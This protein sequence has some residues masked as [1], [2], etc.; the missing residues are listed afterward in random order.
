MTRLTAS[1]FVTLALLL[2]CA[3]GGQI[4]QNETVATG[5]ISP[6]SGVTDL[7]GS[8]ELVDDAGPLE[9][10]TKPEAIWET[11]FE[12]LD[13]M[14]CAAGEGCFLDPCH[15][16]SECQS[17]WC[18]EHMGAG[19]CTDFCQEECPFG[20]SCKQVAGTGPDLIFVCVSDVANLC[21][22]CASGSDCKSVG[23]VDDV[24]VS[25]GAEGAFCGGT[26][27]DDEDCPQGFACQ[28]VQTVD[29]IQTTQCVSLS[30]QCECTE[31][32]IALSLWTPCSVDNEVG[33]C[34]GARICTAEGLTACD[35][36]VPAPE[37]CD[38]VDNDCDGEADNGTCDDQNECTLD[39][40]L[41]EDGCAYTPLTG[42]ECKDGD[43]CT[44]ADHCEDGVCL[45]TPVLCNDQNP[46]TDDGC[47][48]NGG[49]VF[50][51]NT[52]ACDDEDPCTVAD[53][54]KDE[55]C[56][57]VAVDC[58]CLADEDCLALEDG[59]LCNG[60]LYCDTSKL[61]HLC[62]VAEDTV[63]ACPEPE[64]IDAPCVAATCN[65]DTGECGFEPSHEGFACEDGDECTIGDKCVLGACGSGAG[66][67]CNDGNDCTDESCDP[68]TG[69]VYSPNLD[70]CQDGDVCTVG[71]ACAEG[72]C[73]SGIPLDCD[74]G[75]GCTTDSCDPDIGCAHES[76]HLACD[77]GNDCTL[78]D[79][80]SE[81]SC[82]GGP[83]PECDDGN[84]CTT[85]WC[86]PDVGCVQ[87]FN[88]V[89]CDDLNA[90]TI[91]DSCD[92]GQCVA[93]DVLDCNNGNVCTDD[94]CDPDIGCQHDNNV[95]L[96]DDNNTCTTGD[97]CVDGVCTGVGA[98]DC[99]DDN[100]CTK[101]VCLPEGGCDYQNIAGFCDDG[102][103]CSVNDFCEGGA[104]QGGD[105]LDCDDG[106][107]CT[108]NEC[109]DGLCINEPSVGGCDDGNECTEG[110]YCS[111]GECDH[112]GLKDCDDQ[113]ICTT[114]SC[115]P[116]LGCKY[117]VNT[118]P[119][120]DGDVC[121]TNDKCGGGW[122]A[123][124]PEMNCNDGNVCTDDSCH[125]Q[126][127]CENINNTVACND[128]NVCTTGDQC[129]GG[130]CVGG[131]APN[132][133][134]GN[135]CTNDSCDPDLGCV[136]LS[137]NAG[138]NDGNECTTGDQCSAGSCVGGAPPNCDDGNIC[139][140]DSCNVLTGCQN[141][142]NLG[143]CSDGNACTANDTCAGGVCAPGVALFCQDNNVCTDDSC[144]PATG[145]VFANN[146]AG[147]ND[148][149]QCTN[150]DKCSGGQCGGTPVQC[151]DGKACTNDTCNPGTGCV[152]S[153]ISPCCGNGV[154]EGSE[155]C[156]DGNNNNGDGCSSA[157]KNEGGACVP[158]SVEE[159]NH[160]W[161]HALSCGESH[162]AACSRVGKTNTAQSISLGWSQSKANNIAAKLGNSIYKGCCANTM[163]CNSSKCRVDNYSDPY[164]NWNG[165]VDGIPPLY[166]CNK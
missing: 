97:T 117:A 47:A 79:Q 46:C 118:N 44:V 55:E 125:P 30:G 151:N 163:F 81:G 104:C 94:W 98:K 28:T 12:E 96:C 70:P 91:A 74:D 49:C 135:V 148:N 109:L 11:R 84:V 39:E 142:N 65:P 32:S 103:A 146:S 99:D 34:E 161:V 5:E 126:N 154:K 120:D 88:E 37:E 58:D 141:A 45:G 137:N 132:C 8:A 33:T 22:P 26:C 85:D 101:D 59:D 121:T 72:D 149:S 52:A 159:G 2:G 123:S 92:G 95:E 130:A 107:E 87:S 93:G 122:C 23:G 73:V 113:N 165:C 129:A 119:C 17:G 80:C 147:C 76:N 158:P 66:V 40:C 10:V 41:G 143:P 3:D 89:P 16:N 139:T 140:D 150:D 67:N 152:Y 131:P 27:E 153:P 48:E 157:C 36:A 114:D 83:P 127:G 86:D 166:S 116:D 38:G 124:G 31:K 134:N 50:E 60:L 57:G 54:C 35:A 4:T 145:C 18:V 115:D 24:C 128:S 77:D 155:Q 62:K 42:D 56:H 13:P 69:C 144:N 102:D 14:G 43:I 6:D 68:D 105:A 15:N 112:E 29:S 9:L 75:N 162:S 160:C 19:V 63:V 53:T 110:D 51:A 21:K 64:G 90:C 164:H 1:T 25:Y 108:S 111:Q 78:S 71:D 7:V 61:P 106:N 133:D 156:D 136:H 20:W 100:P 82:V 138:C